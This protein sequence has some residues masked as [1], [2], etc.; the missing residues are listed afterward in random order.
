MA[1]QRI[2][3]NLP[4]GTFNLRV[5]TDG[6]A[7][8]SNLHLYSLEDFLSAGGREP[9]EPLEDQYEF[10]KYEGA[11]DALES[12]IL[13]ASQAGIDVE[14]EPFVTAVQTTLDAIGNKL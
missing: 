13:A 11:I 4:G 14:H 8:S 5:G 2:M 9:A 10:G 1:T 12:L 6:G 7:I 3:L